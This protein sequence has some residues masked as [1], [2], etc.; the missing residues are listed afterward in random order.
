MSFFN[1]FF[2]RDEQKEVVPP[3]EQPEVLPID[4]EI[5]ALYQALIDL[6]GT[7][8]LVIQAGRMNAMNSC[9]PRDAASACWP[10]SASSTRIRF[11]IP[12]RARRTCQ[13]CSS[14]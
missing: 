1:R 14:V 10:C 11:C 9:A 8:S 12:P 3:A 5:D 2:H 13:R 7:D 4:R 6:I